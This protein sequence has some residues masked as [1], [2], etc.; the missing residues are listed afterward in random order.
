M[1]NYFNE[2]EFNEAFKLQYIDPYEAEKRYENYFLKY[3]FDYNTYPYFVSLLILLGKFEK[4]N[5]ILN[6]IEKKA[7]NDSNYCNRI[8]KV[9]F[10]NYGLFT[11]RLKLLLFNKKYKELIIYYYQN[12][13]NIKGYDLENNL[14]SLIFY[15]RK[16]LGDLDP[17]RREKN[18]YLYR[19]IV[20]Y[21]ESDFRNHIKKH[22]I[23]EK[24]EDNECVFS[25][26][27]PVDMVIE[28]IKKYI[29][30]NKCLYHGF[31]DNVYYFKYDN[32]GRC[33]GKIT[34][35]FKVV[36]LDNS[37]DFITMCPVMEGEN[38]PYINLNYLIEKGN[39]EVK[40]ISMIDKF[41]KRYKR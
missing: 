16:M 29:P 7:F 3:P 26:D 19:Q 9:D 17:K 40:K 20:R 18:A 28:E 6:Y 31:F 30:S 8:D 4:A 32:V 13:D 33:N 37:K 35:Y 14:N 5:D 27:F 22:L 24:E 1:K 21:E 10:L 15:C 11:C 12:I 36:A 2:Y 41:N 39:N 34:D 23:N 38:L 25:Y